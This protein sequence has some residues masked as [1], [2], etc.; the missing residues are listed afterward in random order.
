MASVVE[1][2]EN[3]VV[4]L[5]CEHSIRD[6]CVTLLWKNV[7]L[8][9]LLFCGICYRETLSKMRFMHAVLHCYRPSPLQACSA[10]SISLYTLTVAKFCTNPHVE[11]SVGIVAHA[12]HFVV[13]H[14]SGS[15]IRHQKMELCSFGLFYEEKLRNDYWQK[16]S[17]KVK[18]VYYL[19]RAHSKRPFEKSIFICVLFPIVLRI[20][21]FLLHRNNQKLW[22]PME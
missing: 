10:I 9:M 20:T 16:L 5:C 19:E 2:F 4:L 18:L 11:K 22:P 13:D 8:S 7:S 6:L 17:K 1:S 3:C 12:N 21:P 15:V 14:W